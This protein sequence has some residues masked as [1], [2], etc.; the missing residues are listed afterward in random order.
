MVM[1]CFGGMFFFVCVRLRL[2]LAVPVV[3]GRLL[4]FW[5]ELV[6]VVYITVVFLCGGSLLFCDVF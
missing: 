4:F 6:F 3:F 1:F 5:F 2:I